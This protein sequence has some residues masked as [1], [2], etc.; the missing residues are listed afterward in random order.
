MLCGGA[1]GL[2]A[3]L[4]GS[5][6]APIGEPPAGG[7]AIKPGGQFAGRK[8]RE[9]DRPVCLQLEVLGGAAAQNNATR[10]RG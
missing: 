3:G 5:G 8:S 9:P 7:R 10:A 4:G 6:R 1:T 2:A